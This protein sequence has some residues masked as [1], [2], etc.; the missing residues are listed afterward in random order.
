MYKKPLKRIL[1]AEDQPDLSDMMEMILQNY[2]Y[3]I[4]ICRN[5][6]EALEKYLKQ[7]FP[8][9]VTDLNMPK[10]DGEY[11]IDELNERKA[12]PILLVHTVV[13]DINKVIELM[14]KGVYDYILKPLIKED[15][16]HRITKAFDHYQSQK[17]QQTIEKEREIRTNYQLNW[18]LWREETLNR[19]MDK[20]ELLLFESLKTNF[21]QGQGFGILVT[22]MNL[23]K[24]VSQLKG[25]YYQVE[26]EIMEMVFSNVNSLNKVIELFSEIGKIIRD[27]LKL[28]IILF[29]EFYKIV[30]ELIQNLDN[31]AK[32]KQ[33]TVKLY[34]NATS[35][36][37]YKLKINK[38]YMKTALKE[39]F[40][41]AFKY[42]N[43]NS[44]IVVMTEIVENTIFISILNNP[45]IEIP[46]E[47]SQLIFEP[48]YR[49]SKFV[50]DSYPTYDIGLGLTL[51]DKIVR[52]HSG[53][54]TM[55]NV[56]SY[57]QESSNRLNNFQIE[58]PIEN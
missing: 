39:L 8:V 31:Y 56:K 24:S 6:K 2:H 52:H 29:T 23:I 34:Q 10:Y 14:K 26:K 18:S 30:N 4:T 57:L 43:R 12:M 45:E 42:S 44:E 41:N 21:S 17:F 47:C 5:G 48:F 22:T 15:F 53:R 54:I 16:I 27:G 20:K 55:F 11:L 37:E 3:Q 58:L 9:I 35:N 46:E 1:V 40:L 7:P 38:E 13:S 32:E 25:D 50:Y 36:K 19:N 51:V 33:Q 28:E 49:I